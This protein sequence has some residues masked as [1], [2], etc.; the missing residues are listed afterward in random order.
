MIRTFLD[1][2]TAHLPELEVDLISTMINELGLWEQAYEGP[3]G[4]FV[5]VGYVEDAYCPPCL[6][7]LLEN[8][9]AIFP[10][11][12]YILLN[13]DA[14]ACTLLPIYEWE[15]PSEQTC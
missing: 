3:L 8:V 1:L 2:S 11:I 13:G 10:G 6:K 9:R 4:L 15:G 12:D 7:L 14:Q 5:W